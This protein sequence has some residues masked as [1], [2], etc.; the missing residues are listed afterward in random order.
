MLS[1]DITNREIDS[2]T[3]CHKRTAIPNSDDICTIH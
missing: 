2:S 1:L 3:R